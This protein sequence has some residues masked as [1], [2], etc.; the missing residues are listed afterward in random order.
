[1]PTVT[2]EITSQAFALAPT[3]LN[4]IKFSSPNIPQLK[5]QWHT[6][7]TALNKITKKTKNIKN[8]ATSRLLKTYKY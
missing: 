3:F 8:G 1:M 4:L 5:W 2:S 7:M 6:C